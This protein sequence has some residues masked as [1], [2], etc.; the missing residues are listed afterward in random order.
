MWSTD[1]NLLAVLLDDHEYTTT[2]V[3]TTSAGVS[4]VVRVADTSVVDTSLAN[5]V[6]RTASLDTDYAYVAAGLFNPLDNIVSVYQNV[7]GFPAIPLFTGRPS[8]STD[9]PNGTTTVHCVDFGDDVINNDFISPFGVTPPT[10]V[11]DAM[12]SIISGAQTPTSFGAFIQPSVLSVISPQLI[13]DTARGDALDT[14]AKAAKVFWMADRGGGF[15]IF[16]NPFALLNPPTPVITLQDGVNGVLVDVEHTK[17]RVGIYNSI[18]LVVER[19][20]IAPFRVTVQDTAAGSP[21]QWGGPMGRRNR[22]VKTQQVTTYNDAIVLAQ[23]IL[24]QSLSL[25]RTWKIQVPHLPVLDP[26]DVIAVWYRNEVTAQVVNT[27]RHGLGA[28][29]VT[30]LTTRQLLYNVGTD[31]T[32]NF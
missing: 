32:A 16:P 6:A 9:H 17:S 25:T 2:V 3:V 23:Q 14:L 15:T 19:Q 27:V 31:Q 10:L 20:D 8:D 26:G 1:P 29:H 7:P 24:S 5:Q 12:V 28:N 21:T 13:F 22:T 30:E 11:T 18:T 4:T